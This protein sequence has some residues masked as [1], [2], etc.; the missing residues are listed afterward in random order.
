[1]TDIN[2]PKRVPKKIPEIQQTKA[3]GLASLGKVLKVRDKVSDV[4]KISE[5]PTDVP[6][7]L[8]I[9]FKDPSCDC[10]NP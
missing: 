1:M 10:C 9:G 5:S 8:R 4:L 3:S 7:N 2:N 6:K